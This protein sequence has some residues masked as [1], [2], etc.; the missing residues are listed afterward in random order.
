MSQGGRILRV[1]DARTDDFGEV[2]KEV[3]ARSKEPAFSI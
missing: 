1:L 2:A 3:S